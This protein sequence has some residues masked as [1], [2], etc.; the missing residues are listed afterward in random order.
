MTQCVVVFEE[1]LPNELAKSNSSD[2]C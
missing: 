1:L 2:E